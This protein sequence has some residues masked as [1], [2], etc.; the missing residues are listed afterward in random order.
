MFPSYHSLVSLLI[1]LN[2]FN[3]LCLD[4]KCY[5]IKFI[6]ANNIK[7]TKLLQLN[8][9]QRLCNQYMSVYGRQNYYLVGLGLDQYSTNFSHKICKFIAKYSGN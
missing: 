3:D 7:C 2:E 8:K 5:Q 1:D 9:Q 4:H 6:R